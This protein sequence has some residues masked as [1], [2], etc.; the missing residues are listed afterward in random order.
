MGALKMEGFRPVRILAD[1][2]GYRFTEGLKTTP[3]AEDNEH[4][5]IKKP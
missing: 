4:G 1:R 5:D 3:P 2:E